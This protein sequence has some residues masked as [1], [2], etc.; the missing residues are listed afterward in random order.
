VGNK[1][2]I[3][4]LKVIKAEIPDY[5]KDSIMSDCPCDLGLPANFRKWCGMEPSLDSVKEEFTS[6]YCERCWSAALGEEQ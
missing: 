1:R 2:V 4:A 3:E 5:F 6:E